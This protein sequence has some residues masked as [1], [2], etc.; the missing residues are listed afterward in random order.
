MSCLRG[1]WIF[2]LGDSSLRMLF[3]Y[4]LQEL[5]A[6]ELSA[7][8][9]AGKLCPEVEIRDTPISHCWQD[10]ERH[11]VRLTY[12]AVTGAAQLGEALDVFAHGSAR[13]GKAPELIVYQTGPWDHKRTAG[14]LRASD[15][16][17]L[18]AAIRRTL[19]LETWYHGAK[20][21]AAIPAC[22][23]PEARISA[24][25]AIEPGS[26]ESQGNAVALR[27][28]TGDAHVSNLLW[29]RGFNAAVERSPLVRHYAYWDREHLSDVNRWEE[30]ACKH[31]NATEM[32]GCRS[33]W[34]SSALGTSLYHACHGGTYHPSL[35]MMRELSN[36][37]L[38]A[39]CLRNDTD[40][41]SS[42]SVIP[43]HAGGTAACRR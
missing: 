41:H 32:Q 27:R 15:A 23:P 38:S 29:V 13:N 21:W 16:S 40:E 26:S 39:I 11:G 14:D 1:T 8:V 37:F 30:Q 12:Q 28:A 22:L 3:H 5:F 19:D 24:M 33:S 9:T 17:I 43:S 7:N 4:W 34:S 10:V 35:A 6:S 18:A 42:A 20:I 31:A 25:H 2:L 36:I